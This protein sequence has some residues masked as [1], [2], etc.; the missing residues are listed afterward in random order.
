M[1]TVTDVAPAQLAKAALRRLALAKLEPTPE[2]YARAYA[3]EAG[4]AAS[5]LPERLRPMLEKVA[6]LSGDDASAT[7]F[8]QSAMAGRWDAARQALGGLENSQRSFAESW[9]DLLER[10]LR[11]SDQASR[12]WTPA[13]RR[14]S[15]QRVLAGSRSDLRRLSQRLQGLMSAWESD[16][17]ADDQ[18]LVDD[19][20]EGDARAVAPGPEAHEVP[21]ARRS[22]DASAAWGGV[23]DELRSTVDV[24]MPA[25]DRRARELA[26][27]LAALARRIAG[28]GAQPALVQAVASACE[29]ARKLLQHRHRLVDDLAA[30]CREL[31]ASLTDVAEDESWARGQ[32]QALQARLAEG[33][34]ARSVRA[35]ATLLED[36]RREQ[37]RLKL[38]RGQ[39]RDALK[40]L[41]RQMLEEIGHL[42]DHTDRYAQSLGRH[43]DAVEGA[44]S[45]AALAGVVR[46]MV[47]DSRSV[48]QLV[49]ST[50]ERLQQEHQRAGE[51]EE[52][53]RSLEGELRRISDEATTDALTQVANRRGL[54]TIFDAEVAR[55]SRAE[56]PAAALSVGLIDI[57]N[58]K[59]LNDSLGHAAGDQAL[60]SLSAAVKQRLRQG[61]HVARYGGEEF[62]I[63]L[64]ATAAG[65]AQELLTRLQRS[66]SS[67]LFMHGDRE[68]FV[69]F[70][71]GVTEW[72]TGET[73]EAALERA[74]EAMYEAKRTGKN[75]TCRA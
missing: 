15:L 41:V 49:R 48:Q 64:P 24:A 63:V 44:D 32:A 43:A 20:G 66:L 7:A 74:D 35:A 14:D 56:G 1:N 27:E 19:L 16:Q 39:A 9:S 59:K 51:L 46:E 25:D 40:T 38:E 62:V 2:N 28:E 68:V 18:P 13:R 22:A 61:D 75:R 12:Q 72:R 70:S 10:L 3:E 33:V 26:D 60:K 73:L 71:A 42:D 55:A 8:V 17:A 11:A 65:D 53:V 54:Q 37:Q 31:G 4:A 52:R 30:L 57:D 47:D 67:S 6:G 34:Q 50:R 36:M 69:T 23:V 5:W 45:L 29:Q 58:F 21:A